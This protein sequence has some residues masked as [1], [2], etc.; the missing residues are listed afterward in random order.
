MTTLSVVIAAVASFF[1]FPDLSTLSIPER[2]KEI[3]RMVAFAA[4]VSST[5][6]AKRIR[7]T[8]PEPIV[9]LTYG[10]SRWNNRAQNRRS[11]A[12]GLA[13]FLDRTWKIVGIP[14]TD[15]PLAQLEAMFR[16]IDRRY[17][18]CPQAAYST[19]RRQGWY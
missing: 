17:R 11:S 9:R 12:F 10:E 8:S 7:E 14:K 19:Y 5:Q 6:T 16:Y 18:G 4:A 13:Q 3:R 15:C 2:E 1:G